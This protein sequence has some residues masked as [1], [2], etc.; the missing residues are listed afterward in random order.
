VLAYPFALVKPSRIEGDVTLQDI[1][2]RVNMPTLKKIDGSL[3]QQ[4][5]PKAPVL[6]TT[7]SGKSVLGLTRIHTEG[8]G[9]I[10]ILRTRSC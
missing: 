10:T 9:T 4:Q 8:K 2:Q 1:N 3:Q 6:P 5:Q 7:A